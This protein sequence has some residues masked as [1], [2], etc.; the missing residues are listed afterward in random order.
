[1]NQELDAVRK[2]L[3]QRYDLEDEEARGLL[4]PICAALLELGVL[5]VELSYSGSG[6]QGAID[7]TSY[8]PETVE[9]PNELEEIVESVPNGAT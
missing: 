9:V 7:S 5:H 6:D 3:D 1:M 4:R 2:Q 8:L